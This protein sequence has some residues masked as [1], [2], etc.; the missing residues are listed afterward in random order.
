MNEADLLEE[1][2]RHLFAAQGMSAGEVELK[3]VEFRKRFQPT[4]GKE[5][6]VEDYSHKLAEMKEQAPA[7][8]HY[9]MTNDFPKLSDD[10]FRRN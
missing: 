8:L 9:L 2:L 5:L 1:F 6:S 7:Y 10:F 4:P 3:I